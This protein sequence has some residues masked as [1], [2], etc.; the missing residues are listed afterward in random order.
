MIINNVRI[1]GAIHGGYQGYA[2]FFQAC[3][4]DCQKMIGIVNKL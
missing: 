4:M 2:I 1:T 3:L